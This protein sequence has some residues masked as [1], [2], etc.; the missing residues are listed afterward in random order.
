MCYKTEIQKAG[1]K[2]DDS[3]VVRANARNAEGPGLLK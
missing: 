1:L 3:S 2:I